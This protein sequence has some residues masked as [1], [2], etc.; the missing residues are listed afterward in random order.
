V[1]VFFPTLSFS[2][3]WKRRTAG[4]RQYG[5]RFSLKFTKPNPCQAKISAGSESLT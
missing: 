4:H 2:A 5:N 1:S 3:A